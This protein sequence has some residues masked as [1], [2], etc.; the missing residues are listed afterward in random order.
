MGQK[1]ELN[2]FD[3]SQQKILF[4]IIANI[5]CQIIRVLNIFGQTTPYRINNE[6]LR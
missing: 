1:V 5:L 6:D 3:R 4:T 2:A